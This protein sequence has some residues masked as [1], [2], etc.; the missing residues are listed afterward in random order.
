MINGPVVI[1]I[2]GQANLNAFFDLLDSN[3][4]E[5]QQITG[6]I[7]SITLPDVPRDE[8]RNF[9][10]KLRRLGTVFNQE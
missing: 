10:N 3:N 9:R 5:S 6:E 4:I 8:Q 7:F 1:D 2:R